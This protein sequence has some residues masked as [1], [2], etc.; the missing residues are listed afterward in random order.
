MHLRINDIGC[1]IINTGKIIVIDPSKSEIFEEDFDAYYSKGGKY[2]FN[3]VK[4]GTYNCYNLVND[5]NIIN[6]T[7]MLHEDY[8]VE[9]SSSLS[10]TKTFILE[11]GISRALC[12]VDTK[13]YS[14]TEYGLG[15][16]SLYAHYSPIDL[17]KTL[18]NSPY[19]HDINIRLKKL[20][21]KCNAEDK[22][23]DGF[24]ISLIIGNNPYWIGFKNPAIKSDHW[25]GSVYESVVEQ[26]TVLIKGGMA[27]KTGLNFTQFHLLQDKDN[28]IVGLVTDYTELDL[29]S[30]PI[31]FFTPWNKIRMIYPS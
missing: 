27:T 7:V 11:T 12:C 16:L 2:T 14:K 5:M 8:A 13:Y 9:S 31:E 17:L 18:H 21:L 10:H 28:V 24:D 20:Y 6:S 3:N 26:T 15:N 29:L 23:V 19:S 1:F 30:L 25:H 22:Y 4:K